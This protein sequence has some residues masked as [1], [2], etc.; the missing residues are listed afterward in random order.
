MPKF[1]MATVRPLV[2]LLLACFLVNCAPERPKSIRIGVSSWPGYEFLFLAKEKGFYEKTGHQI[3][4]VEFS[5]LSDCRRAYERGQLDGMASTLVEVVQAAHNSS[6]RPQVVYAVDYS[7]GGDVVIG[8]RKIESLAMLKGARIGVE[9][10]SLGVYVLAR[11]LETVGLTIK[12]VTPISMDQLSMLEELEHGLVDA[13]V[14]YPPASVRALKLDGMHTIFSSDAIPHEIIDVLSVDE[15]FI[16]ANPEAV[17][18]LLRGFVMAQT[19]ASKFP[20]ESNAIMGRREGLSEAEFASAFTDGISLIPN[21]QQL[22]VFEPQGE[23]ERAVL[24]IEATLQK[25]G[26]HFESHAPAQHLE[27]RFILTQ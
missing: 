6:R 11:A 9:L 4:L 1:A 7:K 13:I 2:L 15:G 24:R 26:D 25:N 5:S 22:R 23:L 27:P 10:D 14:S 19:Y 3:N 20:S 18:K 17:K 16:Q 21:A 8:S 12:D